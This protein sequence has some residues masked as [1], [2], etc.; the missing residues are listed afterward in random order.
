MGWHMTE[1][2]SWPPHILIT[3]TDRVKELMNVFESVVR[4]AETSSSS[5]PFDAF[6]YDVFTGK[7]GHVHEEVFEI[8]KGHPYHYLYPYQWWRTPLASP[9]GGVIIPFHASRHLAEQ[10]YPFRDGEGQHRVH[11]HHHIHVQVAEVRAALRGGNTLSEWWGAGSRAQRE[12]QHWSWRLWRQLAD[13]E[14]KIRTYEKIGTSWDDNPFA[15]YSNYG[16]HRFRITGGRVISGNFEY[17]KQPDFI[18]ELSTFVTPE[19]AGLY[20][21]LVLAQPNTRESIQKSAATRG[22]RGPLLPP[23]QGGPELAED[24]W[25]E[26]GTF[27]NLE[28][29]YRRALG[30]A[31]LASHGR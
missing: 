25:R 23:A 28:E 14:I 31:P 19:E 11:V 13:E 15:T 16:Q 7:V 9:W 6:R 5:A 10:Y 27:R 8:G 24:L 18:T 29:S 12:I 26:R 22:S 17:A 3:T 30:V 1:V 21:P 2:A 4:F 20:T